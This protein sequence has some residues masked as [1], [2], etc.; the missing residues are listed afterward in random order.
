[1]SQLQKALT[2]MIAYK[3]FNQMT[4][5]RTLK[6]TQSLSTSRVSMCHH[7]VDVDLIVWLVSRKHSETVMPQLTNLRKD[8]IQQNMCY[9]RVSNVITVTS[10]WARLHLKSP[11]SRL[12]TQPFVQAQ[13]KENIKA[14]RNWPLWGEFTGDKGPVTENVSIRW[15]HHVHWHLPLGPSY[16]VRLP[17]VATMENS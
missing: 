2:M 4:L 12:L 17:I 16:L 14:P 15:R 1:M 5:K 9:Q 8:I 6:R 13:I 3:L 10:L 7:H 11:A